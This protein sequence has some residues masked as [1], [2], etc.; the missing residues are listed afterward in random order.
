MLVHE[1][2]S[3]PFDPADIHHTLNLPAAPGCTGRNQWHAAPPKDWPAAR[4]SDAPAGG[5]GRRC[6]Q[7]AR[8]TEKANGYEL[9]CAS[10]RLT[11][12]EYGCVPLAPSESGFGRRR[13]RSPSRVHGSRALLTQ[14]ASHRILGMR[15]VRYVHCKSTRL[16]ARQ[17]Q[18]SGIHSRKVPYRA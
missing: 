10:A 18:L 13:S 12:G 3:P 4:H 9:D 6:A 1:I 11:D 17:P 2:G 7:A 16:Y 14:H 8:A 5:P 15:A